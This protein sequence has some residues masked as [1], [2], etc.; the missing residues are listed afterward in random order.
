MHTPEQNFYQAVLVA[1]LVLGTV[2]GYFVLSMI[3]H[4]RKNSRLHK[5]KIMAEISTL[6]NERKRI[7]SDLHDELGP[8]LSAVKLHLNHLENISDENKKIVDFSN[9]HIDEIINKIREISYNLLPNTLVRNG[10]VKAVEEYIEKIKQAHPINIRFTCSDDFVL[11]K[12]KEINMYRILQEVIHNTIKHSQA[13]SLVIELKV[14]KN[15]LHMNIADDGVGFNYQEKMQKGPGLGLLNLQS[16]A[17]VIDAHFTLQSEKGKGT[18][19][20]FEIPL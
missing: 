7:V 1:A 20:F 10:F 17:E 16:R 19:Y 13:H 3:R 14:E 8:V 11:S 2:I 9:K 18:C 4:Q 6:E 5:A 15:I 12:D